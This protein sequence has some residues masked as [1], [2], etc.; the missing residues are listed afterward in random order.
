MVGA[1]RELPRFCCTVRTEK[2]VCFF[3]L[4]SF[5]SAGRTSLLAKRYNVVQMRQFFS[6]KSCVRLLSLPMRG[7]WIEIASLWQKKS[8]K[9]SLPMR[10]EWIEII[11][12]RSMQR[13]VMSL[14]MR[15][16]WIEMSFSAPSLILVSSLPMRGEWIEIAYPETSARRRRSLSPC[17]ESGLKSAGGCIRGRRNAVSPHAGR[18]D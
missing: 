6:S 7:E 4:K 9:K 11:S 18:V 16:E 8:K 12:C 3:S 5:L 15:G 17:G 2:T 13:A 1:I 14:P 10:G